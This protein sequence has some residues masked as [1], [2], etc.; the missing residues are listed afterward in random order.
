MYDKEGSISSEENTAKATISIEYPYDEDKQKYK[1]PEVVGDTVVTAKRGVFTFNLLFKTYP[2]ST[3]VLKLSIENLLVTGTP[4]PDLDEPWLYPIFSR[5]CLAGES[6]TPIGECIE[7][8]E[9]Y[10]LIQA[11]LTVTNC[12]VCPDNAICPG[13]AAVFP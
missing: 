8:K 2:T 11:P 1:H 13:K 6:Y 5:K 9:G 10:F 4:R 3:S 12:K 7:C